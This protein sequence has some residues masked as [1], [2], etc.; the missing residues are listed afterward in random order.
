MKTMTFAMDGDIMIVLH[1]AT[2]PSELEWSAW[3]SALRLLP[4]QRLKL[5]IFTDGG[6]P[7]TLQ[8]GTFLDVLADSQP[9]IAVVSNAPAVRG[10]VT[11]ISWFNKNVKL[12]APSNLADAFAHL[13]VNAERGRALFSTAQRATAQLG[14]V[15]SA[16]KPGQ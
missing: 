10:V 7:N 3:L 2:P 12:F 14:T 16:F 6:V 4:K 8:R 5:L 11:A 9:A 15:L 1:T 13:G